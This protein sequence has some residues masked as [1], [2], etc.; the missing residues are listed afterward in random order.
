MFSCTETWLH[1]QSRESL[2]ARLWA[3]LNQCDDSVAVIVKAKVYCVGI[4]YFWKD[5]C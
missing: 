4:A 5:V 2:A 1:Q 3:L